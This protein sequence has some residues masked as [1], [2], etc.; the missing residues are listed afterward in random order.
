MALRVWLA[1][2]SEFVL[3]EARIGPD[4]V[5]GF[6][7]GERASR[8][9]ISLRDIRALEVQRFHGGKTAAFT[10]GVG[11]LLAAV[12]FVILVSSIECPC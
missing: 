5:V 2:S 9:A 8:T 6:R 1:D 7:S 4:S 11:A 12:Y 10:L 3:Y